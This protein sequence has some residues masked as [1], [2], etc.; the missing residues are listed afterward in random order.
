M[1]FSRMSP[2]SSETASDSKIA[3]MCRCLS[4]KIFEQRGRHSKSD[5]KSRGQS[6]MD[7]VS[8]GVIRQLGE[9]KRSLVLQN[10]ILED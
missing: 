8:K 2:G 9:S 7:K 1:T 10:V 3:F 4:L 6:V 5:C